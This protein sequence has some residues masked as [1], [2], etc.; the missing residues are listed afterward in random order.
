M[1]MD[2]RRFERTPAAFTVQCR[3]RG[4]LVELWE[5]VVTVD[6]S[7]G[8]IRVESAQLYDEAEEM[9]L[10]LHL[11]GAHLPVA[12]RGRVVRSRPLPSGASDC[13]VQFI[14]VTPDQQ[15]AIDEVVQF[16]KRPGAPS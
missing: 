14:D 12:L 2:Q 6:V 3:R 8:G 4:T 13:A 10:R 15:A 1:A 5:E 11:P 7:A 16:L 9:E